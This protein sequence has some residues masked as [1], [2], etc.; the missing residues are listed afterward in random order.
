M[1]EDGEY[2]RLGDT[3]PRRAEARIIAATNRDLRDATR[4]GEFRADL[5][6]RLSVLTIGVPPLR[7][8]GDDWRVLCGHFIDLYRGTIGAFE[9]SEE[10]ATLLGGYAF[11]G[12]VR[13]LRN[14]VVR[15]GTKFGGRRVGASDLVPELEPTLPVTPL[16][17]S[18]TRDDDALAQRLCQPGFRLDEEVA[19][20]ERRLIGLALAR[21]HGN[22]S[23]AARL[24]GVN[25]TTLYSKLARL[26]MNP[27]AE[28]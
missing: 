16:A 1:L 28:S 27:P 20:F 13:E 19:G 3:Q 7:A 26:G 4:S 11:P 9:L 8:R 25:R 21:A 15:L 22:L 23:R 24:L 10:A 5:F 14:I 17:E 18:G 6:H 2:Y 12:N